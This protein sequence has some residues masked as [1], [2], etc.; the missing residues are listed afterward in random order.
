MKSK[1]I[2]DKTKVFRILTFLIILVFCTRV[3]YAGIIIVASDEWHLSDTGFSRASD[4]PTYVKNVA[5]LFSPGGSGN[6]HAYSNHFSLLGSSLDN[7]MTSA[8][9]SWTTGT[10]I[11]FDLPTLATYDAIFFASISPDFTVLTNYVNGGGNVYFMA[12]TASNAG[13][14]ADV[15]NPFLNQFGLE[16]ERIININ[17][18]GDNLPINS[19]NSI[20][21]EVSALYF[22]GGQ[23]VL[24]VTPFDN[25]SQIIATYSGKG[26]FGMY[27]IP[28]PG[29]IVLGSIG[30]GIVGWLRRRRTL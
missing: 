4:T 2:F 8:S 15:W 7:T 9:H 12:G 26:L 17:I 1:H 19:S 23:G 18:S 29:A 28:A 3:S 5:A 6:F 11:T 24:D 30:I 25:R 21:N 10:S 13:S 16:L 20:F 27:I 22:A 14:V